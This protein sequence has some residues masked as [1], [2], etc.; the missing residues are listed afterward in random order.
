MTSVPSGT[1]DLHIGMAS[2]G[3]GATIASLGALALAGSGPV[4]QSPLPLGDAIDQH[5]GCV[6]LPY[7]EGMCHTA[8]MGH[9][10]VGMVYSTPPIRWLESHLEH[11]RSLL[12]HE[13]VE[14][15]LLVVAEQHRTRG[16]GTALLERTE[17]H[18]RSV[19]AQFAVAK[20]RAGAFATMRWYR[21]RGYRIAAQGE[22]L[23]FTTAHG[24]PSNVSDGND[25]HHL[26][27][28]PLDSAIVL[29]RRLPAN[30]LSY[31]IAVTSP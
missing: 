12:V 9:G 18:A 6:P 27:V 19:G 14:I 16:I 22:P 1:P 23:L 13:L 17:A 8:R 5:G 25:G 11:E 4:Q 24:Q 21:H 2:T 28:K 10:V 15:E 29:Q 30:G 7:G 20:I 3:D 26:A 31:L